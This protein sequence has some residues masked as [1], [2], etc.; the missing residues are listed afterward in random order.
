MWQSVVVC[1]AH[2]VGAERAAVRDLMSDGRMDLGTG[3]STTPI[4]MDSF[5]VDS[6]E[7]RA[8]TRIMDSISL[9][10]RHVIPAFTSQV[11]TDKEPWK[12]VK[13]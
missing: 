7:T 6:E 11:H 12:G 10:G 4:E 8:H 9:F 5:Q 13:K 1:V 2:D 3:R